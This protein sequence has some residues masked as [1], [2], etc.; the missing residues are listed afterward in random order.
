MKT[1]KRLIEQLNESVAMAVPNYGTPQVDDGGVNLFAIEDSRVSDR[2][3]AA[4]HHVNSCPTTDPSSRISEIKQVLSHAGLDFD[5]SMFEI[6][7]EDTA[8]KEIPLTQF[9]GRFGMTPED[10]FV[11]DDGISHRTGGVRYGIKLEATR[12]EDSLWTISAKIMPM[13]G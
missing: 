7:E 5:H 1:Y 8:T 3:N 9:G 10:G 2:I 11:D 13:Q 12:G 6:N 4:L